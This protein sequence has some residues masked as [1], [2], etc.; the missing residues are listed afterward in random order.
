MSKWE[1][2]LNQLIDLSGTLEH[3][4]WL[5]KQLKKLK[6]EINEELQSRPSS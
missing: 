1:Q 5:H 2:T 6:T 4:I 3:Q